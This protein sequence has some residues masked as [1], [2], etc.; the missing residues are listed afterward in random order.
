MEVSDLEAPV[1]VVRPM[2]RPRR[3]WRHRSHRPRVALL[4]ALALLVP[5]TALAAL[6]G[7]SAVKSRTQHEISAR[8]ERDATELGALMQARAL[9]VDEYVPSSAL[10]AAAQFKI[11]PAQ[12]MRIFHI[13]YPVVL[14]NARKPVDAN[15]ALRSDPAL[16]ADLTRLH[17]LRPLI[18]GGKGDPKTVRTF[19]EK[20]E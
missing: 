13:D 17:Q 6:T 4:L 12:V 18:D 8:V 15:A 16:V 19:F 7:G 14:H 2:R 3:Q 5:L 1:S 20:F 11:T 9:V 10:T